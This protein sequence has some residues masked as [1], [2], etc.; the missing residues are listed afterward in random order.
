MDDDQRML[1]ALWRYSILG[2]L[3]SARLEHGDRAAY[4]NE[5]AAR[6]HTTPDGRETRISPR[7]IEDWLYAY[8]KGGL[9]ALKAFCL[10]AL[11]P[12]P[13]WDALRCRSAV[14]RRGCRN[15]DT[16]RPFRGPR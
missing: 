2:P 9:E 16:W 8:R 13:L 11:R 4:I 10:R 15:G 12:K 6:Y 7:T 5:A 14:R 1:W 3:V